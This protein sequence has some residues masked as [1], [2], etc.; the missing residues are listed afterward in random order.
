MAIGQGLAASIPQRA[1]ARGGGV[2]P[3]QW[4]Q[5]DKVFQAAV[6]RSPAERVAFLEEACQ[7][8]EELRRAVESML[9]SDELAESFIEAPALAVAASILVEDKTESL[10][11][12]KSVVHVKRQETW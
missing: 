2:K 1:S 11:D 6:E 7:G 8:D 4:L 12:R 10:V 5:I 9:A 3:E